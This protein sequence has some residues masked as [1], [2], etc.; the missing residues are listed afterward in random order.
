MI[1][2]K[3]IIQVYI[4]LPNFTPNN[5]YLENN[6]PAEIERK[7]NEKEYELQN[8]ENEVENAKIDLELRKKYVIKLNEELQNIINNPCNNPKRIIYLN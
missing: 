6:I 1:D 7:L 3:K 2:R 8:V 4:F 5:E